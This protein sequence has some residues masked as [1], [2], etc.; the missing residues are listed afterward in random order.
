MNHIERMLTN[1]TSEFPDLDISGPKEYD[2]KQ[3]Y[4][5]SWVKFK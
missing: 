1:S 3:K 2:C 4:Y 5:T